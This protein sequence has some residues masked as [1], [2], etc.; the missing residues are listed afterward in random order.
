MAESTGFT[1]FKMVYGSTPASS[2]NNLPG[3]SKAPA[4]QEFISNALHSLALAKSQIAKA[5]EWQKQSYNRK[6][7]YTELNVGG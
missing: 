4:A 6:H 1:P 3:L 2:V 7:Q 5:Q